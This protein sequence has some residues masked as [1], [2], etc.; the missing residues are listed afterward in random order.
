[1]LRAVGITDPARRAKAYPFEMS[2]GM[3]QRV[4]IAIA[5]AAKPSLLIA[6][7]PTTGLDVTTQAVIMDLIGD[8][9]RELGMATIFITHDLA[10]AGQRSA[11]IVVMHAGHVVEA[12]PTKELFARPRHPYTAELIA[13]TPDSA[14]SLDA[15]AAIP[16]SLPDLRRTDLPPCRYSERCPRKKDACAQPLPRPAPDDEPHG[17]LLES[18]ARAADQQAQCERRMTTL[19]D[20]AE[21]SKLFTVGGG[22]GPWTRFKRRFSGGPE[23]LPKVHAVDDVS[24]VIDKGE[25]VGLVGESGCGKSTLV[26]ALTRLIDVSDGKIKLGSRELSRKTG[27][28]LRPRSAIAPAFRWCSR[29]RATASTRAS[30]HSTPS[31][32]RCA[33][34][35]SCAAKSFAQR[36]ETVASQCGLPLELLPRFP[37][38]LSGGQRARVGIARAIAVEPDL[39]VLDEPTAALDVSVQVVV[40]QLLQRLKRE[41]GMSYLFVSHDLSV[42]RLLCDRVLVMYLGKIVES[43]PA[44]EVFA[45]PLHPYTQALVAAVPRLH[46]NGSERLRLSGEPMSPI[47]PD[48][49]V[50]RFY[51]R[52][53]RGAD[54]CKTAMPALR[55]IWRPQG[56]LPFRRGRSAAVMKRKTVRKAKTPIG[57]EARRQEQSRARKEASQASRAASSQ[58]NTTRSMRLVAA[59]AQALGL[60]IEPAWQG[61]VKFNLQLILRIGPWS[62]NFP[63]PTTPSRRRCSM[64]ETAASKF[65]WNTAAD[66]A[67]AVATGRA[68]A[69]E[70]RRSDARPHPRVR[71]AAQ[72]LHR[73]HRAAR[74]CARRRSMRPARAASRSARSPAFPSRSKICSTSPACRRSPARR[75]TAMRRRPRAT[76]R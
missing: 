73:G 45:H 64:L 41:F 52:C 10:L 72:F 8:L 40:L 69:V 42:V 12:A 25:T 15:L 55:R 16:G 56:R 39:L 74:S 35:A 71:S 60:T 28:R 4:M 54:A 37:H 50:C 3:C 75:S 9:A 11:R 2:G 61:G 13:A 38:Q 48:P 57:K 7:E 43:G 1:M 51:G 19:L 76:R 14:T 63:C 29:T 22:Q 66:I 36:V 24:F 44:A 20:V 17:R 30:P 6:D 65:M 70:R 68:S 5:L 33:G 21:V 23:N 62:T 58:P 31:P 59:S 32:I 67:A 46:E 53:P 27:A 18:P 47:D 34:C 49:N 26:R